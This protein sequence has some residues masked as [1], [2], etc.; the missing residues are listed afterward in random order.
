MSWGSNVEPSW[1][2]VTRRRPARGG[3]KGYDLIVMG[4]RGMGFVEASSSAARR[5]GGTSREDPG[6]DSAAERRSFEVHNR[7]AYLPELGLVERVKE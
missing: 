2:P 1:R 6:A 5:R 3:V 7:S 4:S